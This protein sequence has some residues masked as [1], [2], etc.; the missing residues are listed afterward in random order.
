MVVVYKRLE[1]QQPCKVS[2]ISLLTSLRYGY[3][4]VGDIVVWW[5]TVGENFRMLTAELRSWWHLLD[6]G[7]RRLCWKIEDVADQNGHNLHQ[8][9]KIVTNTFPS[10]T[11]VTNMG[12][13]LRYGPYHMDDLFLHHQNHQR[14]RCDQ[15]DAFLFVPMDITAQNK[16]DGWTTI[17]PFH[18]YKNMNNFYFPDFFICVRLF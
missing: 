9:L 12:V 4:H 14:S 17:R 8:H 1:V 16:E 2:S 3:S 7:A 5:L 15:C 18:F 6:V 11:S 13:A 10:S